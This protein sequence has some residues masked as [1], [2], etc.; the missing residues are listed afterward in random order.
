MVLKSINGNSTLIF[1]IVS[2]ICS[3]VG[4]IILIEVSR[5]QMCIVQVIHTVTD[6]PC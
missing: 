6:L 2:L 5:C 3:S 4:K 1:S